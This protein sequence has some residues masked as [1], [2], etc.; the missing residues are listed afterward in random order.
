MMGKGVPLLCAAA[1]HYNRTPF[2]DGDSGLARGRLDE[3]IDAET[4]R[5][6]ADRA[7]AGAGGCHAG[8]NPGGGAAEGAAPVAR[9]GAVFL[10]ADRQEGRSRRRQRLCAAAAGPVGLRGR[11]SP[12][13]RGALRHATDD[14]RVRGDCQSR[15]GRRHQRPCAQGR[16]DGGDQ[17]G[18]RRPP[19]VQRQDPAAGREERSRGAAHRGRQRALPVPGVR[20]FRCHRGGRH[21]AR[22]RQSL[23][24]RADRDERHHLRARTHAGHALRRAGFHPD[25]RGDQSGQLRRRARRHGR[26]RRRH[27]HGD[28][29]EH[30]RLARHRLRHPVQPRQAG[31]RQRRDGA[32]AAAAVARRQAR[33]G[34]AR[35][36]RRTQA[37]PG[38]RRG[39]GAPLRQEPRGRGRAAWPAT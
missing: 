28:L 27:Q 12:L 8:R 19:R 32:Q 11:V 1:G 26:P 35:A 33:R 38:R 24:R 10:R 25:G 3:C 36:G 7:G 2:F 29:F 9:G 20:R 13:L 16:G 21:G 15:R 34:D 31:G 23:R 30:G 14:A 37:R 39:G 6:R 5:R 22:H 17:P 4:R 18:A